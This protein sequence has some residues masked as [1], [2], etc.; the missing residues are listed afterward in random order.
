MHA[1]TTPE[2]AAAVARVAEAFAGQAADPRESGCLFC[3]GEEEIAWLRDPDAPLPDELVW[4]VAREVPSHWTDNA[5]VMRRVLPR[6][7][8]L[9]AEGEHV[10]DAHG[11][12]LGGAAWQRWPGHQAE[13]VHAFLDAYWA[14][15]LREPRP[16]HT[17]LDTFAFCEEAHG[18]PVPCLA[19]WENETGPV[20]DAHLLDFVE[21]RIDDLLSPAL[22]YTREGWVTVDPRPDAELISWVLHHAAPRIRARGD[23]DP[24]LLY[25]LD[26][27]ALPEEQRWADV[28]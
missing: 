20:A 1:I 27:L 25:R 26:Q 23:A 3:Y 28:P 5:A 13:A 11:L 8:A 24:G 2:L 17:L 15:A 22:T 18:S 19:R 10:S 4:Y 21:D 14:A 12:G 16:A 6:L 9:V 7:T